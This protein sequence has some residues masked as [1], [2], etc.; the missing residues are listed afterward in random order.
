ML[1]ERDVHHSYSRPGIPHDN[2][3]A[4]SFFNSLK[5]ES[6]MRE[7]YPNS[8]RELKERVEEY[9]R[10]YNSERSHEYLKYV[11]PDVYEN[12]TRYVQISLKK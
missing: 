5:N 2:T 9:M 12:S 1:Q 3:V 7:N 8:F 11:S 6:I 4:E 10:W